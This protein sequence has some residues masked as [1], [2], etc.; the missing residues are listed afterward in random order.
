MSQSLLYKGVKQRKASESRP[1]TQKNIDCIQNAVE[2]I[3]GHLHKEEDIWRSL[4]RRDRLAAKPSVFLWKSIHQ[5]HKIGKFWKTI[6]ELTERRMPCDVCEVEEESMEHILLECKATGQERVWKL[7][8]DLWH[9]AMPKYELPYLSIGSILGIGLL[10]IIDSE[11]KPVPGATRLLQ[12]LIS[13]SAYLIWLIRNEWCMR[14]EQDPTKIHSRKEVKA[15]WKAAIERRM[16]H[17]KILTNR[18]AFSRKA[19]SDKLVEATWAKAERVLREIP[20]DLDRPARRGVL[21]G[22]ERERR[23]RGRNR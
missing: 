15:R 17:D 11:G 16:R 5:I 2:E 19:L 9:E 21:V 23:P 4:K 6:P 13:E 14:R 22:D 8:K 3:M 7:V 1:A 10:E 12:I 20:T 18:I